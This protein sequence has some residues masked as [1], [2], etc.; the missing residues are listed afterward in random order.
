MDGDSRNASGHLPPYH[1]ER[2]LVDQA[3]WYADQQ[4]RGGLPSCS[5]DHSSPPPTPNPNSS[6]IP[7]PNP[8]KSH[9]PPPQTPPPPQDKYLQGRTDRMRRILAEASA[10]A[11]AMA[12]AA[13]ARSSSSPQPQPAL[14]GALAGA[15]GLVVRE[16][17]GF[18]LGEGGAPVPP[19]LGAF[20]KALDE[21]LL[22]ALQET[23][24][25]VSGIFL[26]VG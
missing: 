20:V 1:V 5:I 8:P 26:Q 12:A 13:A 7:Y 22:N 6:P 18:G 15:A 10:V 24:V 16:A 23:V 2:C 9:T 11:D 4:A 21:R 19:A 3:A 25:N 14:P 17:W